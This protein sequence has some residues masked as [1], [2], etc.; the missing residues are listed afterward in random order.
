[1][2]MNDRS[3]AVERLTALWALSEAALGG[4]LQAVK[5]PFAGTIIGSVAVLIICLIAD[6]SARK[7]LAILKA[8]TIVLIIKMTI[9]PYSPITACFAVCFQAAAGAILFSTISP[10]RT[11]A[12]LLGILSLVECAVQRVLFLTVLYGRSLWES[13]NVFF[14]YLARQ[15]GIAHVDSD[16]S[17]SGWLIVLYLLIY[18]V[19]GVC[20]GLLGG[21]LPKKIAEAIKS[22]PLTASISAEAED[23][24]ARTGKPRKTLSKRKALRYGAW[25]LFIVATLSF[26]APAMNGAA[27]GLIV[28]L[29]TIIV[30]LV[31]YF[32]VAPLLMK[33]I[34][35][36]LK[37]KETGYG[38]D[39]RNVLDLFPLL[40]MHARQLWVHSEGKKGLAWARHFLIA[41]IVFALNV[42]GIS[43]PQ[44]GLISGGVQK[45]GKTDTSA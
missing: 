4:F 45:L 35:R 11:A 7:P 27:R 5:T 39:I 19:T 10:F 40:K 25:I 38:R 33:G 23:P 42:E 43:N 24:T 29:R 2:V 3:K 37:N 9:N 21:S 36:K 32:I 14:A 22:M 30:L 17:P 8:V 26:L 6:Y 41:M 15:L 20:V 1:V 28:V 18:G 13:I 16:L 12:L 44:T 34:R 31:W